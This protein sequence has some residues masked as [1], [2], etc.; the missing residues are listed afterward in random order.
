MTQFAMVKLAPNHCLTA[1]LTA[2]VQLKPADDHFHQQVISQLL[3]SDCKQQFFI[4]Y[5]Q[6][7]DIDSLCLHGQQELANGYTFNS[8]QLAKLLNELNSPASKNIT[9]LVL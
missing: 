3:H 7:L 5:Y 9:E 6:Q 1:G 8:T 2:K 4:P